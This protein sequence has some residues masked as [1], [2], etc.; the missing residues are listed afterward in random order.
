VID[1]VEPKGEY[2]FDVGALGRSKAGFHNIAI[3]D[4]QDT[5]S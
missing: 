2:L 5:R 1:K 3:F 4:K